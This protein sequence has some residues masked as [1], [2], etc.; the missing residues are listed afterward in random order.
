MI[1]WVHAFFFQTLVRS[2][3]K[4]PLAFCFQSIIHLWN[5]ASR[6]FL[7]SLKRVSIVAKTFYRFPIVVPLNLRRHF[8]GK[9]YSMLQESFSFSLWLLLFAPRATKCRKRTGLPKRKAIK[10]QDTKPIA[11]L[12]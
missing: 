8:D 5:I 9:I 12:H 4:W 6:K 2:L 1:P 7:D 10:Q 3:F 11:L